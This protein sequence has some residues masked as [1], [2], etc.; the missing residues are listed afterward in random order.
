MGMPESTSQT[1]DKARQNKKGEHRT[2]R[3]DARPAMSHSI[4]RPWPARASVLSC[5]RAH[6][7]DDALLDVGLEHAKRGFVALQRQLQRVQQPLGGEEVDY[8]PL[9]D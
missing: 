2:Q 3:S 8:D 1:R 4:D 5:L 6:A 7:A 9:I